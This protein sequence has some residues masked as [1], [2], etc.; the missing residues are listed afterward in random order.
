MR[1]RNRWSAIVAVAL[2]LMGL[3]VFSSQ[4]RVAHAAITISQIGVDING[5]AA[6]DSSGYSVAMSEDGTRIAI[7]A[8]ANDGNGSNSGHVRVYTR[9]GSGW[10]QTGADINGEAINDSAGYSVAMSRDGNR[11]AIGA[12]YN[13]GS[14]NDSGHVRVYTWSG[15][16]WTQL[17]DDINGE[18]LFDQS[19]YSVA[20]SRDGSRIAIGAPYNNGNGADSGHVRVYTWS[21]TAWEKTGLDIDGEAVDDQS[22]YSVAMSEDGRRIA[23]GARRNDENGNDSGHVRVY[24]WNDTAWIKTG[25]DIDGEAVVDQSG[26]SVAMS[27]DGTRIAIGAPWNDSNST[28][29]GHVRVYTWNDTAWIKTGSDIDGEAS[30]DSSGYSVAMS[31]DGTRIAIGAKWNDSNGNNNAGHVRVYALTNGNWAKTG[32]DMNGEAANDQSGTSV[33]M[34]AD[35]T[36]ITIGAIGNDENGDFSGHVRAFLVPDVPSAPTISS[37]TPASGSLTVAFTSGTDGG[38]AITNYKYSIDGVNYVALNPAT[39]SSPFTISGL[40]NRTTYSVTIKAVNAVGD[41]AASNAKT[42]TPDAIT[43]SQIG[44]DINGE[45]ADDWSGY[46]V[47]MSEDGTRIAI[48]AP[49]NGDESGHVRVYT[50]N[51]TAWTQT[52]DDINGE[53]ANDQSGYS[54]AMSRDGNRIAIGSVWNDG[55]GNNSGHVRVYTWNGTAWEKTGDDI[56]GEAAGDESGYSVAMSR[57]GSRIAIGAPLNDE[58]GS[59]SGH[60]RVYT[61]SGTAW[62]KTGDDIDGEAPGDKSGHS[63][64]MS[65]DGTRIAIGSVWNDGNGDESGHVR[66]YTWNGTTWEKTGFDIEGEA[67][68]DYSGS[69][70]AMSANGSRIAIGAGR[71]DENGS[72]SGHVRVYTWNDTAWVKTGDDIDGEAVDDQSGYS[73]ALSADGTRIAIGSVWNDGNGDE[74]GHVRIYTWNGTTWEKTGS[75][76]EGEAAADYSGSSLAMSADGT[77]IAIGAVGNDGSFSR[78]GQVRAFLVPD[79]PSA[80]TISSVPSASG[81]LTVVFTPGTDGGSAITNY[82]YSV[83]GVN[84]VALNPATTSGPFTISGLTNGTTYSV[85][86]K[87][88]NTIG[89]SAASNAITASPTVISTSQLGLDID[90]E[91]TDDMS[92]Y[93]VAM[94]EDGT[95]IAIG[96][97]FNDGNGNESG[98]VR[99]YTKNGNTWEQTGDDINGK[100]ANDRSGWSVAMSANGSRIV[101]GSRDGGPNGEGQ[102]RVYTLSGSTWAQTGSDIDG[103]AAGD[104]SGVSVAMSANGTHIAIAAPVKNSNAGRVRIYTLTNGNWTQTGSDIDGEAAGDQAS[105]T[106][107]ATTTSI[108]M[109]ANGTHIAIGASQNDGNG[110]NSG[111]VR[112]YTLV[113]NTWTQTGDDINGETAGD[114]LGSSVAMSADGTR[115]AIG[116]PYNDGN[117]TSAGHV[118]VYTWSGTAWTQTGL[119]IDGETAGDQSGYSVAM[120]ADGTRIAIGA[121]ANGGNAGHVRIHTLINGIWTQIG[122]DINGEATGDLS[123]GAVA[124]SASGTRIAIGAKSNRTLTGQVRVYEVLTSPTAPTI[125]SVTPASGSLRVAITPGADGGSAITNYKYSINGTDYIALNPATTSSSFTISGLT[126]GTTYSVTIKA[127]NGVG[128]SPASNAV[129]GSPTAPTTSTTPDTTPTT[130]TPTTTT[131]TITQET[132]PT[133]TTPTTTTTTP[134]TTNTTVPVI[135]AKT[136]SIKTG[137]TSSLSALIK[138][139]KISVSKGSKVTGSISNSLISVCKA[140]G[141]RIAAVAPGKCIVKVTMTPKKGKTITKS[142]TVNIVGSPSVKRGAS[143]TLINA[144]AAAGLTTG[145]GLSMKASVSTTSSKLC[146]ASR[147]KITA[148]KIGRCSVTLTVTSSSGATATKQLVINVQ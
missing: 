60:V 10:A 34:S 37:V 108:A 33:A 1:K 73:V 90:G 111:H 96:A 83:D 148:V 143:I 42:R 127:E 99:V 51:G 5:E 41:S 4:G 116:A 124:M 52:G 95:R 62:V 11:I 36:H 101:I 8:P 140:T 145:G 75:D 81:S 102:V 55:N 67:A 109:S 97:P 35:G 100:A 58:N 98:H 29:T 70:L 88:V 129:T 44:S 32:D 31:E 133:T 120:S 63:V 49:D 93:S 9:S 65:Q 119:D 43:I 22:G 17:G 139:A 94:S 106:V 103:E 86:I 40:T 2:L 57:D 20:M 144:A 125:S 74:S 21:G 38:S 79:L 84:Y 146:K 48:G 82:K 77:R 16:A 80:P 110:T 107:F 46:S 23:I 71:N 89:D 30:D 14:F 132:T 105:S 85:T 137:A 141:T 3:G 54:V 45:A 7:G 64:A 59:Y 87:A 26:Y 27:A 122:E 19:G 56:N 66:V 18:A 53:G 123:G 76:I 136:P 126:N 6:D 113:N 135:I 24:T 92:G 117:G 112:I 128:D 69:S 130:S 61:W 115:I 91:A 104:Q 28:D 50:W 72:N 12:P 68:A 114:E 147:T 47:A 13:D 118:R 131:P 78:A 121:T 138:A 39:T 25:L 134:T 15:T 142:L